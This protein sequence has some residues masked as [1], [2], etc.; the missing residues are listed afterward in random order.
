MLGVDLLEFFM[1]LFIKFFVRTWAKISAYP[2]SSI[3][4]SVPQCGHLITFIKIP[5]VILTDC[6]TIILKFKMRW[7]LE[8]NHN[9]IWLELTE[10]RTNRNSIWLELAELET[11]RNP[12]GLG[13]ADL[14]KSANTF[15]LG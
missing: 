10:L 7:E 2:A 9:S 13:L 5:P 15:R 4:N 12:I 1:N 6:Y 14:R 3:V 11:N 8:S